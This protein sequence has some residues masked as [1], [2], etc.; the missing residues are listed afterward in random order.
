MA[1]RLTQDRSQTLSYATATNPTTVT[2]TNGIFKQGFN[3]YNDG[4]NRYLVGSNGSGSGLTV[5]VDNV[6]LLTNNEDGTNGYPVHVT[7][8][9]NGTVVFSGNNIFNISNEVT[10]GVTNIDF[11]NNAKVEMNRTSND[12]KFSEFY[13]S[14]AGGAKSYNTFRMGDGSSNTARTYNDISADY[15]AIYLDFDKIDLRHN[16]YS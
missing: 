9:T 4:D 7:V 2:V 14:V 10:R 8:A 3:N 11:A 1:I 5:N 15:P 12:K 6:Q 13:F 16:C